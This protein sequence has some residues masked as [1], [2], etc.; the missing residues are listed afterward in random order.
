MQV[1]LIK[2]VPHWK[3]IADRPDPYLRKVLARESVSRW[4][5]RRWR[6]VHTDRV[7]ETAIEGPSTDRWRSRKRWLRWRPGSGR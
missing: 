1:A 4:R 6:E 7:P 3:K 5:R 2:A